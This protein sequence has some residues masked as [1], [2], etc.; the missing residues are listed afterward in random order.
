MQEMD[1]DKRMPRKKMVIS[2]DAV[3]FVSRGGRVFSKQVIEEDLDIDSGEI[4]RV[5]DKHDRFIT[6]VRAD[7]PD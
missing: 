5:M 3:P 2:D 6:L 1:P 7:V 4:V